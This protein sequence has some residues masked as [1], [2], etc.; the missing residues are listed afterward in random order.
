MSD[1]LI[2]F[3]RSTLPEDLAVAL[4]NQLE[5]L[6]AAKFEDIFKEKLVRNLLGHENN[7]QTKEVQLNDCRGWNDFISRRLEV[8]RSKRE[9]D[10]NSKIEDSP[11]YQQHIFFIAALAAVGAFLQSNVTGPPLPFSSAK[12]LFL[13]DIEADTKSV[14]SIRASLI[15]L[16]GADGIAEYKLTPNV[17]LLCLADTILTH[18][19]LKKNIPPAI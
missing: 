7:E 4:N 13:A 12:A 3:F 16:L 11:A 14:K 15:D 2:A 1:A 19:A 9:D 8:L 17:E 5:L 10:G 18:P 6:E